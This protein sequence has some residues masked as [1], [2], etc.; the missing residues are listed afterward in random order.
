[1]NKKKFENYGALI[2]FLSII[3]TLILHYFLISKINVN[4]TI[5][6]AIDF[7]I[8]LILTGVGTNILESN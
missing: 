7:L 1:M 8:V 3:I 4:S 6:V 2:Y 5:Q